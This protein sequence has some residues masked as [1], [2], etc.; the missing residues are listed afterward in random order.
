MIV[1]YCIDEM[2]AAFVDEWELFKED[3][4]RYGNPA[5]GLNQSVQTHGLWTCLQIYLTPKQFHPTH[6]Q[7]VLALSELPMHSPIALPRLN[8]LGN[9]LL[10]LACFTAFIRSW[11]F[12]NFDQAHFITSY[13]CTEGKSIGLSMLRHKSMNR[14]ALYCLCTPVNRAPL[15]RL[16][17]Q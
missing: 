8:N 9:P 17:L 6:L 3:R 11:R 16:R 14:A 10:H 1:L 4:Y 13:C 12:T 15:T 2:L 5:S 7:N